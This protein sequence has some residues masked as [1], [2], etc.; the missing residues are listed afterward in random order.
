MIAKGKYL[1]SEGYGKNSL[2]VRPKINISKTINKLGGW[3]IEYGYEQEKNEVIQT[4]N[5][6]LQDRSFD[7]NINRFIIEN[8][9]DNQLTIKIEAK[10]R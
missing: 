7:F 4:L 10:Q 3:T 2:F 1:A 9:Q 5:Q 6:S 8:N